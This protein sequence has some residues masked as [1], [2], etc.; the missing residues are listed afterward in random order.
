VLLLQLVL[1][2]ED[3][4]ALADRRGQEKRNA[5]DAPAT[6]MA[7]QRTPDP[8]KPSRFWLARPRTR[9][10]TPPALPP[11]TW[12]SHWYRRVHSSEALAASSIARPSHI[13]HTGRTWIGATG[14]APLCARSVRAKAPSQARAPTTIAHQT[15]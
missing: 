12:P 5:S 15:E 10:I 4:V 8:A 2:L 6:S 3:F 13:V 9:P 14:A 7:I 1:D 11:A